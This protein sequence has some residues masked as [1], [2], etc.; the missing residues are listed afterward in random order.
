MALASPSMRWLALSWAFACVDACAAS[1]WP[2]VEAP[3][4]ARLEQVAQD[5]VLN[6]QHARVARFDLSGSVDEALDFYRGRFGSRHVENNVAG[7]RTIAARQGDYF[8]TVRLH[9]AM[10]G[11]VQGTLMTTR[12]GGPPSH[13]GV[14]LDTEALLPAGSAVMQT[15][16][17]IDNG[18]PAT[19]V[20]AVNQIGVRANRDALVGTL[21]T[22]GFHLDREENNQA[23]GHAVL[24]LNLSSGGEDATVTVTDAG[25]YR[26]LVLQRTRKPQ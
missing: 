4:G 21:R 20:V 15:Q 16:E 2:V 23:A 3:A 22:R 25:T 9:A 11:L 8:L 19:L 17:S 7:D 24:S 13:S 6:G 26:S 10:Q 14:T 5:F 18:V 12:I 1:P